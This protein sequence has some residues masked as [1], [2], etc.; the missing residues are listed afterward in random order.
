MQ[1]YILEF[2]KFNE[3]VAEVKCNSDKEK[4]QLLDEK[5]DEFLND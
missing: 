1:N 4:F 3:K 2:K 5:L